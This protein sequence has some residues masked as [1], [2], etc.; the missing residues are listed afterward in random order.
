LSPRQCQRTQCGHYKKN[1]MKSCHFPL[2]EFF[3]MLHS[4][5]SLNMNFRK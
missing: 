2:L 5:F 4:K 3:L 1:F